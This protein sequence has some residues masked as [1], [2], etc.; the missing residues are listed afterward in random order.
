MPLS[1]D[2]GKKMKKCGYGQMKSL[3]YQYKEFVDYSA[4]FLDPTFLPSSQRHDIEPP[5]KYNA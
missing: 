5:A 3:T 4:L 2:S 1:E